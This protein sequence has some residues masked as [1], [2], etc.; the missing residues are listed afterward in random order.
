MYDHQH[1]MLLE[2]RDDTIVFAFPEVHPDAVLEV[3]FQRTLRV[4]DDGRRYPLPPGLGEFPLER[5]VDHRERVPARW[6]EHGGVLLPMAQAEALWIVLEAR[7]SA[8]HGVRYPFAVEVATG[9]VS[10]VTGEHWQPGL[11]PRDYLVAPEQPWL[12]GYYVGEGVVRQF[13]AVPLGWGFTAEEQLTGKAEHGGIQIQV[14][15]M[16]RDVFDRKFPA[17]PEPTIGVLRHD[18]VAYDRE[19]AHDGEMG[20][21]PGGRI[22]QQVFA[23]PHGL[24]SW[25]QRMDLGCFVHIASTLMW[26]AI[27]GRDA[28]P[29]PV[30]AKTYDRCGF[31][32]F[33][34]YEEDA[35][36]IFE[37]RKLSTLRSVLEVGF[38]A[39]LGVLPENDSV[40]PRWVIELGPR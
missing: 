31:P 3:S 32:W 7:Y 8:R 1:P 23:D 11:Q 27:T 12:D 36:A 6:L 29:T 37:P 4:P 5:V 39:G 28:P 21:A 25:D 16:R 38:Q 13:V 24:E 14:Y 9:G 40:E 19:R 2:L 33:R 10:A 35:S 26:R 30:T 22:E 34:Y 15:P 18:G 17:R 20:L